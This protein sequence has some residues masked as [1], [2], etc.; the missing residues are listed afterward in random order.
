VKKKLI[1]IANRLPVRFEKT[2]EGLRCQNSEGGL[3]TGLA[4]LNS[5]FV[6]SW[7][8]WPGIYVKDEME[9]K[10]IVA[11]MD[12]SYHPV[13]LTKKEIDRYYKGFSNETLWPLFHYFMNYTHFNTN[14][15]E[16][17]KSVNKKF[18]E[19]ILEIIE[20]GDI[21][22]VQD[23][24]LMLLPKLLREALNSSNAIGFFLHIPFP[25]YELFRTLPWRKELLE[26]MLGSDLV[27]FHT[28][29]YLQNFTNTVYRILGYEN[30]LGSINTD[31]RMTYTDAFPMSIN[32]EKFNTASDNEQVTE[33][34]KT[35]RNK[36]GKVK[37]IL[38]VDRLD[39]TKGIPNRLKAFDC[40][41]KKFPELKGNVSLI[42]LTVPSRDN[43]GEYKK[44]KIEVDEIVGNMNGQHSTLTWTPI[45]Y[46]YRSIS[47]EQLIALYNLADICFVT[48][49]RDGMNL[50]AKEY[51]ASKNHGNGVLILSEMAGS[52]IELDGALLVN[53]NDENNMVDALYTALNMEKSEQHQR[54]E[55]MKQHIK[56]NTVDKWASNFTTELIQ[57]YKQTKLIKNTIVN[58]KETVEIC[59]AYSNAEKRLILLDYDGTLMPFYDNPYDAKPDAELKELLTDLRQQATV[60][61]LSGRDHFVMDE[62]FDDLGVELIAEHGIWQKING[63]WKQGGNLSTAWKGEVYSILQEYVEKTP[64]CFIEEKPFSLAFHYR[65]ADS[66]LSELRIPQLI[67]TLNSV[68]ATNRLNLLNGNK[69][70]EVR[71]S[72]IDKGHAASKWLI[73]DNWDFIMA[74]GDDKTDEDMFRVAPD[75]A[76]TIKV[77]SQHSKA[78]WRI[79]NY[80]KVRELLQQ[81]IAIDRMDKEEIHTVMKIVKS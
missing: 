32:F 13:F 63:N 68:C 42:M 61:L 66:W 77:G 21:L 46:F 58:E 57:L 44:L 78:K 51:V 24:H 7:V 5:E 12:K 80:Q 18:C 33:R 56:N 40:L 81:M 22:W 74:I 53:P 11:Q 41:L 4:S 10:E 2:S 73:E 70:I 69:V 3:A 54:L 20:E 50:V 27:G 31:G 76:Y 19:K 9:E 45:H 75:N 37:L 1:I 36:F 60:V 64:G 59:A 65:Q 49:L 14:N 17:Y 43:V 28:F 8:G 29:E 39:Y 52:A 55:K 25:S 26:G 47:F 23:Y 62:W 67:N 34:L 38:S 72:G 6:Q 16:A 35:F 48:P 30:K 15:W 71:I 79:R